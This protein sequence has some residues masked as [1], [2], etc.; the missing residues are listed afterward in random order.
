MGSEAVVGN[1]GLPSQPS[2][3]PLKKCVQ[4]L[5]VNVIRLPSR[6]RA[7][8]FALHSTL[9]HGMTEDFCQRN[10]TNLTCH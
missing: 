5:Q 2:M 1:A 3:I 4:E 6:H 10:L 8:A 9:T 7:L